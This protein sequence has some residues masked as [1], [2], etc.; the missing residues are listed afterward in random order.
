MKLVRPF[1][2]LQHSAHID[3]IVVVSLAA[4]RLSRLAGPPVARRERFADPHE[5][6]IAEGGRGRGLPRGQGSPE[7]AEVGGRV[8]AIVGAAV[9]QL[10][11][12]DFLSMLRRCHVRVVIPYGE[13]G[14]LI[15]SMTTHRGRRHSI[16]EDEQR[17]VDDTIQRWRVAGRAQSMH[18][19]TTIALLAQDLGVSAVGGRRVRIQIGTVLAKYSTAKSAKLRLHPACTGRLADLPLAT[20][21]TGNAPR[22]IIGDLGL[23]RSTNDW[24]ASIG[25]HSCLG[26]GEGS[27][28]QGSGLA[29]DGGV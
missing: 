4:G 25:D 8:E 5:L 13:R 24:F 15:G 6:I 27:D 3:V 11:P 16:A 12:L 29:V 19:V 10:G 18:K 21:G 1:V 17:A 26:D 20:M 28:G 23:D 14:V 7:G 22:E 9:G 2:R